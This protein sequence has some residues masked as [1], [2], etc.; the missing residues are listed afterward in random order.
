METTSPSEHR[1][2]LLWRYARFC[3]GAAVVCLTISVMALILL[4]GLMLSVAFFPLHISENVWTA[5]SLYIGFFAVGSILYLYG[6]PLWMKLFDF[7]AWI[8]GITPTARQ[9]RYGESATFPGRVKVM[10]RKIIPIGA[11]LG[12]LLVVLLGLGRLHGP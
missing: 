8:A 12:V 3:L 6:Y 1:S 9:A 4:M 7:S 2:R 11:V 5:A 10:Q